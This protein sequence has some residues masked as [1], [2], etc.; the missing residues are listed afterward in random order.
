M[1][2]SIASSI[3]SGAGVIR[4]SLGDDAHAFYSPAGLPV[5]SR[6]ACERDS[7]LIEVACCHACGMAMILAALA[8]TYQALPIRALSARSGL[9]RKGRPP[10]AYAGGRARVPT[11]RG[12][13]DGDGRVPFPCPPVLPASPDDW[14]L[15]KTQT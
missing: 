1:Q 7:S 3:G 15:A 5:E 6:P 2:G 12:G 13:K 10:E 9:G 14:R 11:R 8:P 4:S